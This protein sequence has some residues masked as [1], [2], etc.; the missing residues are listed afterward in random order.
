MSLKRLIPF[1][2]LLMFAYGCHK[3]TGPYLS[4]DQLV[5][6]IEH[7]AKE[8]FDEIPT[9]SVAGRVSLRTHLAKGSA[10]FLLLYDPKTG[11][12][13][14]VVD[15]FF[16]PILSCIEKNGKL[17]VFNSKTGQLTMGD[18]SEL[19]KNLTGMPIPPSAFLPILMGCIPPA[20]VVAAPSKNCE[21]KQDASCFVLREK[22]GRFHCDVEISRKD[23]TI[24]TVKLA[25]PPSEKRVLKAVFIQRENE[26]IPKKVKIFDLIT[27]DFVIIG[28]NDIVTGETLDPDRFNPDVF[29]TA[30]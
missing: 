13:I 26:K 17:W 5:D 1:L 14:D 6:R 23:G 19:F 3:D 21:A 22:S 12:R 27:G 2:V 10:D 18:Q 24:L 16:R 28:Y 30:H 20:D 11:F 7:M 29:R 8:G 9:V 25:K 4:Q 15:P